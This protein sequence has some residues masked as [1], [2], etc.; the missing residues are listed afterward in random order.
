MSPEQLPYAIPFNGMGE[1]RFYSDDEADQILRVAAKQTTTGGFNR[2][3]LVSMAAEL[4]IS[5]EDVKRA[6]IQVAEQRELDEDRELY[7]AKRKRDLFSEVSSWASTA[8][9]LFGINFLTGPGNWWCQWPIGIWGIFVVKDVLE[10][11]LITPATNEANFQRWR[12]KRS[13]KEAE[14]ALGGN[15]AEELFE[16]IESESG[17][18]KGEAINL[19]RKYTGSGRSQATEAIENY[20]RQWPGTFDH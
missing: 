19:F 9:L 6:E 5:E 8:A 11:V 14:K 18:D 12:E 7:K 16:R 2:D 4:G 1:Q 17:G 13:K 10:R 3:R 20:E 15:S